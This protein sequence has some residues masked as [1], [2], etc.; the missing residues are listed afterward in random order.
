MHLS[1]AATSIVLLAA[2]LL[3]YVCVCLKDGCERQQKSLA[4]P[5]E[6]DPLGGE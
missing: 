3:F 1:S 4:F 2:A 5:V 6:I